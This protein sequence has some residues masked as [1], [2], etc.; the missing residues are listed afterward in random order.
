M[1]KKYKTILILAIVSIMI[2]LLQHRSMPE[3]IQYGVSFSEFRSN[4]LDLNPKETFDSIV[5]D[6]G[7]R[8]FRLSS[9]WQIIEPENNKFNFEFLDYQIKKLA[10]VN[11]KAILTLG[12]R[13]PAW[14]ECHVPDWVGDLSVEKKDEELLDFIKT[15]VERYK[16]YDSIEYWQVENEPF[17]SSFAKEECGP[18]DKDFLKKE[19]S[20]VK[21]IDPTRKILVTDSGN[22]GTWVGAFDV[23]DVFGTS[24]Y[25]FFWTPDLGKFESRLP[26][27]FYRLKFN[28]VS[29]LKGWRTGFLIELPLEPW[30][31]TPIID[32]DIDTQLSRMSLSMVKDS[33]LFASKTGFE[34][35]YLWGAEWWYWLKQNGHPEFWEYA[36]TLFKK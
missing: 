26:V 27:S 23:G 33:I 16:D 29:L 18:L 9:H 20:L 7:V 25:R 13:Q 21:S 14:P 3:T 34:R 6:L 19:I 8:K 2:F 30:L 22:L 28:V 24:L 35:Q 31:T 32:A 1:K 36:K 4:G 11:G 15:V 10:D 17:L 12:R 5:D